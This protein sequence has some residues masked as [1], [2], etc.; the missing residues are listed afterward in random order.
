MEMR[1]N[2]CLVARGGM[3]G[4]TEMGLG[5]LLGGFGGVVVG[6]QSIQNKMRCTPLLDGILLMRGIWVNL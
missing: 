4:M 6:D 3:G 2:M 5:F 1:A